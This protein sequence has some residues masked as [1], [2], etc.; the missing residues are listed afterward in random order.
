[1][2]STTGTDWSNAIFEGIADGPL[3]D[4]EVNALC[5]RIN[6]TS[7]RLYDRDEGG[8]ATPRSSSTLI[9]FGFWI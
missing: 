6:I 7:R 4:A 5:E 1:M 3:S 2:A 8:P 9:A